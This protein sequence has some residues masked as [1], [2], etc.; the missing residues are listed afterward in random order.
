MIGTRTLVEVKPIL[1]TETPVNVAK[2]EAA[3]K[4]C[5]MNGFVYK[6]VSEED[7]EMF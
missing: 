3:K 1:L 4:W 6:I 7:L 5:E 2:R